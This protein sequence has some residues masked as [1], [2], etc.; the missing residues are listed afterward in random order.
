MGFRVLGFR[1]LL[2]LWLA[3][4]EEMEK[5][6]GTTISGLGFRVEWRRKWKLPFP[7]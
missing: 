6:M 5:K 4:N 3:G 1:V 2:Y 7:V